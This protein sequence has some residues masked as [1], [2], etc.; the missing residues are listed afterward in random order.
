MQ[1]ESWSH[2]KGA[3]YF[4]YLTQSYGNFQGAPDPWKGLQ[5]SSLG[6]KGQKEPSE[7]W[8]SLLWC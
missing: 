1:R 4:P 6:Q 5:F 2:C 3:L 8:V 7:V